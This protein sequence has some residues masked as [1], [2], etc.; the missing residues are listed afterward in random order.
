MTDVTVIGGG[1]VGVCSAIALQDEGYR[2]ELV[3][4]GLE[5]EAASYGNCGLLAV[6]EVVPISKPGILPKIPK[7]LSDPKSPLFV[8]PKDMIGQMPWLLRFLWSGRRSKVLE[9]AAG[10]T[11]LLSR[12]EQDYR[13]LLEAAGLSDK[14]V[15]KENIMA[16][17]SKADIDS[18][19]FTWDLRTQKGFRHRFLD[20]KDLQ[21]IEPALSGPITCGVLLEKWLQFSDPGIVRNKLAE[22]FLS[23]G[24]TL[25]TASVSGL[26]ATRGHVTAI[27]LESGEQVSVKRIVL[28]AGAWSGKLARDIGVRVPLAALQGYHHQLPNPNVTVNHAVLYANGGF[29]LTPMESGLRIAGTIEVAGLDPKPNFERANIIAEKAK[30]V[31]PG[32]NISGGKQWMGPR[33]FMPDTMP[34]IDKA[35]NHDNVVM[36]FGHGQVGMTLGAT[37]G[38]LVADLVVG[39][40]PTLDLAPY[41]ATRFSWNL[42][43]SKSE[44]G[45]DLIR[46]PPY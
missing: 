9:I 40:R 3:D 20:K 18:D 26:V 2:V 6:G 8:R 29:V 15:N 36:A 17:N 7:W 22:F 42:T 4:R 43:A 30:T 45:N 10:M 11:P 31:L 27:R 14:L 25:R 13:A 44:E 46:Y 41:R 1:I 34:V 33:P 24:G 39:R 35:P 37:T 38:R 12:A 32:L 16:F 28:A 5:T 19:S 21:A 23:R